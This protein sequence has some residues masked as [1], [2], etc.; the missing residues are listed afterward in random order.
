MVYLSL[1]I[2]RAD[3]TAVLLK[4]VN[5]NMMPIKGYFDGIL[6]DYHIDFV[7]WLIDNM[8]HVW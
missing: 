7:H 8:V 3:S 4:H 5:L 2:T 1:F 6:R